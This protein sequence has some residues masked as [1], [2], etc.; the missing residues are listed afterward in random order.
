MYLE[1]IEDQSS[2]EYVWINTNKVRSLRIHYHLD[3]LTA[4]GKVVLLCKHTKKTLTL[5][6]TRQGHYSTM[7]NI[8]RTKEQ[9]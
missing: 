1:V 7:Y 9:N 8:V 3:A 6:L 2:A 4:Q 5:Q